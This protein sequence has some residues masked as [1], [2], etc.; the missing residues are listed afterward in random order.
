[1][2]EIELYLEKSIEQNASIYYEKAKQLKHKR[3]GLLKAI[4]E[5]KIKLGT[6]QNEKEKALQQIQK[7][8][9]QIKQSERKR[10]WYEKFH[11]F[12]SSEGFL[13]IGGR[14][15]T[16]N[17]VIVKKHTEKDDIVLHTDM[18]GSPFFVIKN[19]KN[20]TIKTIQEAAQATASYSKAWKLGLSTL[21]VFYVNPEQVSKKTKAGEYMPKGAFM[22]YGE[23]NYLHPILEIAVG[24]THEK[25]VVAG[26]LEAVKVQTEKY[27][28]VSPGKEKTSDAAK[29][30]QK[31]LNISDVNEIIP[32]LPAGGCSIKK[33]K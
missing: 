5:T 11:W 15:A 20:A 23:T 17:E 13:C 33:E 9:E 28:L 6:L 32:M 19:G 14:D 10:E 7:K 30:I 26:P 25:R 31:I 18:A 29:R 12:Y 16:T 24:I 21:D 8:A 27:V 1:M 4:E 3:D 2:T 22:I